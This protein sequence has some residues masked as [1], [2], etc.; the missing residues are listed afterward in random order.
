MALGGRRHAADLVMTF[1]SCFEGGTGDPCGY[2]IGASAAPGPGG[3]PAP[4]DAS[5]LALFRSTGTTADGNPTW[6]VVDAVVVRPPDRVPALL[7]LCDG[8]PSVAIYPA[9]GAAAG[10]TIPAQAAWG[11]NAA[12]TALVE[13]DPGTLS[14]ASVGD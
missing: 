12:A 5:L 13:V 2:A 1:G 6:V 4:T 10:A 3:V 8:S 14:C 7:Q 9:P 11:A